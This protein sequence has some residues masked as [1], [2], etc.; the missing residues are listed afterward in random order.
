MDHKLTATNRI[1]LWIEN[2]VE[3]LKW[4]TE[5][6]EGITERIIRNA[7]ALGYFEPPED[8]RA[9][10]PTPVVTTLADALSALDRA[11]DHCSG[12]LNVYD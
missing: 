3:T 5:C 4:L 7:R 11:V 1:G 6:V 9:A 10:A 8:A 12:S 2:D